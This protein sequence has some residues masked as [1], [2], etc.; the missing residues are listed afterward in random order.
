MEISSLFAS[1]GFKLNEA[2]IQRV[3]KKISEIQSKLKALSGTIKVRIDPSIASVSRLRS[4]LEQALSGVSVTVNSAQRTSQGSG[5]IPRR[6]ERGL[7]RGRGRRNIERSRRGT[8]S[9]PSARSRSRS[10]SDAGSSRAKTLFGQRQQSVAN[11][12]QEIGLSANIA[13]QRLNTARN[14]IQAVNRSAG[15]FSDTRFQIEGF[16]N[17]LS[18]VNRD[19]ASRVRAI[20]TSGEDQESQLRQ[21]RS[22]GQQVEQQL[23]STFQ[24][25]R[26]AGLTSVSTAAV[27]EAMSGQSPISQS[28][29]RARSADPLR[30]DE[31]IQRAD[32]RA[33]DLGGFRSERER[34]QLLQATEDRQRQLLRHTVATSRRLTSEDVMVR[35][36]AASRINVLQRQMTQVSAVQN[37]ART[38]HVLDSNRQVSQ[39]FRSMAR[40]AFNSFNSIRNMAQVATGAM[41]GFVGL[42]GFVDANRT[43]EQLNSAFMAITGSASDAKSMMDFVNKSSDSLGLSFKDVAQASKSFAAATSAQGVS[44]AETQE[45]LTG[46]F[47][48]RS[49]KSSRRYPQQGR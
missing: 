11:A 6:S 27:R 32:V 36:Q 42:T 15:R 37:R 12:F 3:D 49:K 30:L 9:S 40:Q 20:T 13:V 5:T 44:M 7:D 43:L 10:N 21:L 28:E 1:I 39:S 24:A 41:A 19:I 33:Q 45:M 22:L 48:P 38:M 14:A 4:E 17:A 31:M 47:D 16:S 25:A 26:H 34:V 29:L 23:A 2:D 35:Q 18:S 46:I 8:R